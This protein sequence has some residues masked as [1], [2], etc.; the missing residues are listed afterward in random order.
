MRRGMIVPA[1]SEFMLEQ[2]PSKNETCQEWDKVDVVQ[3]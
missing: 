1:L 3:T 2:G